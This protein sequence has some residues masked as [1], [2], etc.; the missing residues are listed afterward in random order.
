M[1]VFALFGS[2]Q[3]I[4]TKVVWLDLYCIKHLIRFYLHVVLLF[5]ICAYSCLLE[6][7]ASEDNLL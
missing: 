3:S 4:F 1:H 7:T 6:Y 2:L 5:C